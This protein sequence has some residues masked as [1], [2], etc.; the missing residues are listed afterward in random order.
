MVVNEISE[1]SI[2]TCKK[3][4][5]VVPL[6]ADGSSENADVFYPSVILDG[7]TYKM[8]YGG[9][10]GSHA[11]IHYATSTDGTTWDKHGVVVPLGD[12]GS[13]DDTHIESPSVIKDGTTYK[14][15]YS[16]QVCGRLSIHY[17]TS[18]DGITWNKQ[19]VVVPLGAYGSSDDTHTYAPSVIKDGTTYK[20]WYSG[21]DGGHVRIHY[22]TTELLDIGEPT[23]WVDD[24]NL[25]ANNT[26]TVIKNVVDNTINKGIVTLPTPYF[27]K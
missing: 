22:A 6:G 15:W 24:Q 4:G 14:M 9:F 10:D 17:A 27:I 26:N 1:S 20:M 3:Y 2:Q 5:V 21:H 23:R 25:S 16:C 19:G 7:N 13:S 8:W 12:N 11:R 18:K